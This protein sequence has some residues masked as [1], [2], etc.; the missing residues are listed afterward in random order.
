MSIH[1]DDD[2]FRIDAFSGSHRIRACDRASNSAAFCAAI[3]AVDDV[4]HVDRFNQSRRLSEC[5][6]LLFR[7]RVARA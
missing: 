6:S 4:A 1:D 7:A 3:H 2:A 5:D